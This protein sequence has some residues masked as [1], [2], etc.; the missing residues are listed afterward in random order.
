MLTLKRD[1]NSTP[2]YPLYKYSDIQ[3]KWIICEGHLNYRYDQIKLL[4]ISQCNQR[5]EFLFKR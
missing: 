3:S 5:K 1:V 4:N 2:D